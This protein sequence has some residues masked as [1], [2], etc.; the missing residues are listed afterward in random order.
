[1]C[2][3]ETYAKLCSCRNEAPGI[4]RCLD[5]MSSYLPHCGQVQT[6][7]H[8]DTTPCGWA[9]HPAGIVDGSLRAA[10]VVLARKL[11]SVTSSPM[12]MD[13]LAEDTSGLLT[14]M[15]DPVTTVNGLADINIFPVMARRLAQPLMV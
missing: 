7:T 9:L 5:A 2:Y 8:Q 12:T 15:D 6:R 10:V 14:N 4:S 3:T 13:R 11:A 1:M